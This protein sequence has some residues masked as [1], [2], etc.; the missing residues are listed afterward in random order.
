MTAPSARMSEGSASAAWLPFEPGARSQT[1]G[2][3]GNRNP[4]S[5]ERRAIHLQPKKNTPTNPKGHVGVKG[6]V[7]GRTQ[8]ADDVVYA[9]TA[10]AFRGCDLD[11]VL[12]AGRGDEAAQTMSLPRRNLHQLG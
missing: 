9:V 6:K 12:L 8:L 2:L 7:L 5:P 3:S 4:A 11:I 1:R 10:F